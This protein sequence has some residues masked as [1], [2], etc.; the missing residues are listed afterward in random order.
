MLPGQSNA[1]PSSFYTSVCGQVQRP[2]S[3]TLSSSIWVFILSA[4]HP[5]AHLRVASWHPASC[6][7]AAK[8]SG[9]KGAGAQ[10]EQV[11]V[12]G[13]NGWSKRMMEIKVEMEWQR[14]ENEKVQ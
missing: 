5:A 3:H 10:A 1:D 11:S 12:R 13:Q 7:V 6:D 4:A 9:L 8:A 2:D 14:A